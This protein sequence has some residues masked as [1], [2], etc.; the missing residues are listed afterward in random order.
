MFGVFA[1]FGVLSAIG[2]AFEFLVPGWKG[3][4]SETALCAA[5][6]ALFGVILVDGIAMVFRTVPRA[7]GGLIVLIRLDEKPGKPFSDFREAAL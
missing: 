6:L 5:F 4:W 7:H 2:I 3:G 1:A